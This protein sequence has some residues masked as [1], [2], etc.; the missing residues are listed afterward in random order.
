[1]LIGISRRLMR[2][3]HSRATAANGPAAVT[4]LATL[5]TTS[6]AISCTSSVHFA[7]VW[8]DA[9]DFLVAAASTLLIGEN[10]RP[11]QV[12]TLTCVQVFFTCITQAC[13]GR[14]AFQCL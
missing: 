12:A 2:R 11:N 4:D 8:V 13:W 9:S 5:V 6:Q 14:N 1:M 10:S 7:A 3:A